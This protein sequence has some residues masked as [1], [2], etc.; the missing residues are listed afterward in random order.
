[1]RRYT[2]K[3][4]EY[5]FHMGSLMA[6]FQS[7]EFSLRAF[8]QNQPDARPIG[9]PY[10]QDVYATLIGEEIA[11][12]ELSSYDSLGELIKK[13]NQIAEER[14]LTKVDPT[15]VDVRDALA[16]GRISAPIEGAHMR[17]IK[18]SR[19]KNGR[20]TVTFNAVLSEDWFRAEK[21]RAVGALM[22]VAKSQS[23]SRRET[24]I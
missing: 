16:H 20:V 18:Y 2:V 3:L 21:G 12:S 7:L 15:L 13:Y 1:M 23:D 5:A 14:G 19:P 17:L 24:E 22:S 9:I 11:E 10:G 6:N 8:L 4:E